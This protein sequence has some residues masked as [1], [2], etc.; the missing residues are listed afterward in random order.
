MTLPV[1]PHPAQ[2]LFPL[3][4]DG[5]TVWLAYFDTHRNLYRLGWHRT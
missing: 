4:G 5:L 2:L 3:L 1:L